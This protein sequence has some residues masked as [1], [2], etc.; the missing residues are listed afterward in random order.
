MVDATNTVT[1]GWYGFGLVT[2]IT[3][4]F[5][6]LFIDLRRRR[7]GELATTVNGK[8]VYSP[9]KHASGVGFVNVVKDTY[10][11]G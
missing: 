11:G 10:D 3:F 7:R 9:A 1:M 5:V 8:L 2:T 6:I 4:L